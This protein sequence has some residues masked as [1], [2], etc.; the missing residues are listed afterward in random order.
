MRN[1][2]QSLYTLINLDPN[3][4]NKYTSVDGFNDSPLYAYMHLYKLGLFQKV[5]KLKQNQS[6]EKGTMNFLQN[7]SLAFNT[8]IPV[9][10]C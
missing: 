8:L 4:G 3:S 9:N 6:R 10:F 5:L 2:N 1:I 7:S